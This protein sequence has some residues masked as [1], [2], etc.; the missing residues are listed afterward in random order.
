M[1]KIYS[2]F[3]GFLFVVPEVES[4]DCE[5]RLLHEDDEK[6][7]K[8]G[9]HV[10]RNR[11]LQHHTGIILHIPRLPECLSL[12]PNWLHP[13][14]LPQASVSPLE[15]K[16]NTRLWARVRGEANLDDWRESLALFLLYYVQN[17]HFKTV[18][19]TVLMEDYWLVLQLIN[20]KGCLSCR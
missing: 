20:R 5:S 16:G 7:A 9:I 15:P 2:V 17:T 1:E 19:D 4:A 8:A 14:P 3:E 11:V 12:H 6:S 13:P 10:H 18:E